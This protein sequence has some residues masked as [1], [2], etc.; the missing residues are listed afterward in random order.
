[1]SNIDELDTFTRAYLE[2][3]LWTGNDESDDSGGEPLDRN[4]GIDDFAP[5]TVTQAV[6]DCADFRQMN[7]ELL[8]Q[9]GTEQQNG[10]DFSLSRNGHGCGFFDRGY[11]SDVGDAL[12]DAARTYGTFNLYVGDDGLIYGS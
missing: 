3:A 9:A 10:H 6:M 7:K 12:Q 2:T 11:A 5:E 1:M 8:E 4:Y